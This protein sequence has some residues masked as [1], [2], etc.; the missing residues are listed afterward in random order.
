LNPPVDLQPLRTVGADVVV[1][2]DGDPDELTH[3]LRGVLDG[4]PFTVSA[5]EAEGTT[6]A[7]VRFLAEDLHLMLG[8]GNLIDLQRRLLPVVE[9]V[10]VER[11][12][13]IDLARHAGR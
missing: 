7:R 6:R 3:V 2:A 10:A 4:S 9:V 12:R 13:A 11:L 5:V 1:L 8:W